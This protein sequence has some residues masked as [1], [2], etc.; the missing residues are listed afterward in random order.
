MKTEILN[1]NKNVFLERKELIVKIVADST[2]SKDELKKSLGSEESTVINKIG[3]N[4]GK[5]EFTADVFIYDTKEA[6]D[7]IEVIP[8]KIQKKLAEEKKKEEEAAKK[9]EE[10]AKKA[11]EEAKSAEAEKVE[12]A[13]AEP[14]EAKEEAPAEEKT[15]EVKSE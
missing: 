10:E 9:A 6:K 15:E 12:E 4:F 11:A 3:K 13:P 14:E 5:Q 1:E 7:K 2:P 8:K